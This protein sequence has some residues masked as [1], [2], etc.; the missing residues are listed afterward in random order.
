[1]T[2]SPTVAAALPL[3]ER[4]CRDIVADWNLEAPQT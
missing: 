3:V 2:L 4:R 1:M